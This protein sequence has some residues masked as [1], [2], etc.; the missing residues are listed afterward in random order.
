VAA[1]G[2][3]LT[4]AE[5]AASAVRQ[6]LETRLADAEERT[7][8]LET[9]VAARDAE[10]TDLR[11]APGG[12]WDAAESHLVFF[13]GAEGYELQERSGPPPSVG[14]AVGDRIVTRVTVAPFP[15][16]ALPCAYLL[17]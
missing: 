12:R 2:A 17:A 5:A 3:D 8:S 16:S 11:A 1:L 15:G 9:E 7:A 14:S 6:E 10:L 13:Q 4:A